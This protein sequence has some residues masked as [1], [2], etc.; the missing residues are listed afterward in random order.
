MTLLDNFQAKISVPAGTKLVLREEDNG[1]YIL[2]TKAGFQ[3][4]QLTP[5]LQVV[6]CV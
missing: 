4:E 2:G 5:P 1:V 3:A 6:D